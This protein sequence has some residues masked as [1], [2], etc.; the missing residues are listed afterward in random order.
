MNGPW[1]AEERDCDVVMAACDACGKHT[2]P[3]ECELC[4]SDAYNDCSIV[5]AARGKYAKEME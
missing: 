5:K 1:D 2:P 4:L 3:N